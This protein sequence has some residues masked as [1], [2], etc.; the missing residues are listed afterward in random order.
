MRFEYHLKRLAI[1]TGKTP[2]EVLQIIEQ[3]AT[4]FR[5][6]SSCFLKNLMIKLGKLYPYAYFKI[7]QYLGKPILYSEV[8][9]LFQMLE[10]LGLIER[11]GKVRGK[12]HFGLI[13]FKIVE[14]KEQ[15]NF[16]ENPRRHYYKMKGWKI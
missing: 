10:E 13:V 8:A 1:I 7:R 11:V 4:E 16:W 3:T 5:V 9:R 2:D 15:H 12:G 14:G 6:N